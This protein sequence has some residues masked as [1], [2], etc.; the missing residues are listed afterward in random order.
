[1]SGYL[2]ITFQV[3]VLL[4]LKT[5]E[6]T[7]PLNWPSENAQVKCKGKERQALLDFKQ[8]LL[9][10]SGLLSTWREDENNGDCCKWKRVKCNNKTGHVQML[11]LHGQDAQYLI[12]TNITALTELQYMEYLDLSWNEFIY[13]NI[14]KLI[15]SLTK[16][17]YLNLSYSEIAGRIPYEIGNLSKL[18]YLNLDNNHLFGEIP[19]QLG[20]LMRLQYL[21]ISHNDDIDGEI[22]FQ[23]RN[24]SHL[25]YL[26]LGGNSL[27]GAIPFEIG[28]L[29]MLHTLKLDGKFDV[30]TIDAEWLSNLYSLRNLD[31][32]SLHNI[33]S[34]HH[35]L[36]TLSKLIPN[37]KELRLVGC[38]LL[39]YD[40]RSLFNSHSNYSTSLTILDLS[41][42]MLTSSAFTWLFNISLNLQE[43]Y[44]SHNNFVL[45]SPFYP[46]FPSLVILD[47][48]YN[49]MT[50]SISQGN[51]NFN[52]NLQELRLINCSLTDESFLMPPISISNSTSSL[53]TLD[54]SF[55][56]LK[57]QT[58]FHWLSSFTTNLY[59][60]Y[61]SGNLLEG[62]IPDG[63][64]KVM[65][66][67]QVLNL[68]S[69]KLHGE[70][71]ASFGNMC[72]LQELYL[73]NNRFS[74]DISSF[75]QNSS[76]CNRHI[77]NT[78]DLSY[79]Q[80]TGMLPKS[81]GLLS[82]LECLYLEGNSLEGEIT[83]LHFTKFSNLQWLTLSYNSL[84]LK[85]VS[86]WVPPFQL[87]ELR[88]ASCKLG[89]RFPNW[90]QTQRSLTILDISDSGLNDSVPE[91][92]W[93]N[94]QYMELLNMSHNNLV[95]AIPNKPFKLP[96]GPS[97]YLN[98]NQFEGKI[99]SFLLQASKLMLFENKFSYFFSLLCDKSIAVYL[100]TLDL[101][102]NHIKGKLPNCWKSL[103]LLLFLDLSNNNLSGK[104]PPSMGNLGKLEALVLRNNSLEGEL[105]STLKNCNSL[106]LLDVGEN[107]FSGPVPSW[108]G[109]SM[110]QLIILSMK[111]NHFSGNIPI[112][113]CYLRHI[114]LLDLSRNNLSKGIPSCLTN[115]TALSEKNINSTEIQSHV[116]WYNST[117]VEN[118]GG[119]TQDGYTLNI[120]LMWK[121]VEYGFKD[122][123]VRLKSIDISCNSL[124]G[125][126]PKEVG[127]LLGLVSLNLSRNNLSG[128]IPAEIGNLKSLEFLD[129]SRNHFFGKIPSSLSKIDR[130]AVLDLS[131]NSLSG[132]IPFGRQLQT[133]DASSFEGNLD[134]CGTPLNK[135]C[136]DN[137]IL[138]QTQ[139]STR[140]ETNDI[141]V[142]YEALYMSMGIGYFTGFL[143]LLGS[144]L[145]WRR[146]RNAYMRFLN[147]LTDYICIMV[148]VNVA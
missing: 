111:E 34:S 28:N 48:S 30:K 20:K 107:L 97:V 142:F 125:E 143:G 45:S 117:Y 60:L 52:S 15:G 126:I 72:T 10:D 25:W 116:Y 3:L 1:M 79:N 110:Q 36:Q 93:N 124:T 96:C 105:P 19:S 99:P 18:E 75:I 130:L 7:L 77:F 24:L 42:N 127:Y 115:F 47:L 74:G 14:P 5:S 85:F 83:E 11:D 55:N 140:H 141:S 57:S 90:L 2:L 113:L 92:L 23:L 119:I 78:L 145:F 22:P 81:I 123:Q 46:N 121:G 147:K 94:S 148:A 101:S 32:R 35:W 82:E 29:S 108:I 16:L 49:N 138:I 134:L 136:P 26:D 39:D 135:S 8:G 44:L 69:N 9:D 53:S 4:L 21:D 59:F 6:S 41:S 109:E 67:L 131:S 38:S 61:L 63:F 37:L 50:S 87:V 13:A 65:N 12:G 54:L 80:I 122:P 146:W 56:M 70:I 27:Y 137:E 103:K 120:T 139:E 84:S 132:E 106:M 102:N 118:Y 112:Q 68:S 98:S 104:I 144:T 100:G 95:G 114:Q 31:L 64:G 88:L 33:G 66:S 40:I 71:P 17:R 89:S 128:E 129:L 73:S 58:I 91:W 86:S 133:F 43:L 51:F 76:W 62:P